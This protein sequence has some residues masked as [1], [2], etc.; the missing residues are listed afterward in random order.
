MPEV[1][2]QQPGIDWITYVALEKGGRSEDAEAFLRAECERLGRDYEAVRLD[3]PHQRNA[4]PGLPPWE[5][6]L[7]RA[8]NVDPRQPEFLFA[9]RYRLSPSKIGEGGMGVVLEGYDVKLRRSVA[10]K[11][12]KIDDPELIERLHEEAHL[13]A[14]VPHPNVVVVYDIGTSVWGVYIVMELVRGC[15]AQQWLE[16]RKPPPSWQQV[17]EVFVAAGRGLAAIHAAGIE[18]RDVKPSNVLMADGGV[19]KIAD[20]G[21]RGGSISRSIRV[22]SRGSTPR[23]SASK[24]A[25][26]CAR[27]ST[28][29][30]S[31]SGRRSMAAG[32]TRARPT[33]SYSGRGR[34]RTCRSK[35]RGPGRRRRSCRCWPR[36]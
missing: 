15:N 30:A 9:D 22:A 29:S 1:D 3:D 12:L 16:H 4:M 28:R 7:V 27:I 6:L 31:R 21:S 5:Q 18:H 19:V 34:W 24:A 23:R 11:L 33:S 2:G 26:G 10:I 13:L 36:R 25:V 14:Q 20:F 8:G 17:F 32:P 35:S